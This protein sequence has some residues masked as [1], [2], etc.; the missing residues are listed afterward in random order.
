LTQAVARLCSG[1]PFFLSAL[2]VLSD[3]ALVACSLSGPPP[4]EY[5]LGSLPAAT[6]KT[7][8]QTG[9]PI[10]EIKRVQLPDYL[11][12]TDILERRGNQLVPSPTGRWGERLSVGMTRAIT[13]SLAARL[14]RMVV[15]AAPQA[16]RSAQQILVDVAAFESRPNHEV[17]LVARWTIT[18]GATHRELT[19]Q[20]ATLVQAI[21]GTGD[22]AVVAAMSQ[23]LEDLAGQLAAGIE[24][25]R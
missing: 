14:P 11:D 4:A 12:T 24:R 9:L 13:V 2:F 3:A 15:T 17:V 20:Q 21:E 18:D 7:I 8:P 1:R 5:A 16:G 19:A 25:D 22:S 6:T 10:V 23:G